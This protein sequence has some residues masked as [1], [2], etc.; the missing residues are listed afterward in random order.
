MWG[1][2]GVFWVIFWALASLPRRFE[3]ARPCNPAFHS[4]FC[5]IFLIQPHVLLDLPTHLHQ[6][7]LSQAPEHGGGRR[8]VWRCEAVA[9]GLVVARISGGDG[10]AEVSTAIPPPPS[11]FFFLVWSCGSC[12]GLCKMGAHPAR[13][14]P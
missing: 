1:F 4:D 8:G 6:L 9:A 7:C 11:S 14:F 2:V 13:W 5:S 10:D 12:L 3:V